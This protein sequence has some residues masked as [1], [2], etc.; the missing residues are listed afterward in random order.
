MKSK[1]LF[2]T[3]VGVIGLL[4]AGLGTGYYYETKHIQAETK[5]LSIKAADA[6]LAGEKLDQLNDLKLQ[7]GKLQPV[8]AKLDLALPKDKNQSA[9]VLQIQQLA[10]NAG[11]KLPSASFQASNG[12]PSA[13]SQT[14]KA[15]GAALALPI[16][17]QLNGSYA[18]LQSFLQQ[19]EHLSRYNT[20]SSLAIAK[21]TSGPLSFTM[22][23]NV[24]IKP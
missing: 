14:I 19:L 4:A 5:S 20:V 10:A 7:F 15:S 16:S 1:Q 12:L 17:F 11:M 2:F 3:L 23:V 9:V 6:T 8:L 22:T 21:G 24:Y 13:T 18:Q